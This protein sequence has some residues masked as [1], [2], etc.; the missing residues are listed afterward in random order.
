MCDC[1]NSKNEY[2][3]KLD[4]DLNHVEERNVGKVYL[5]E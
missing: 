2:N 4:S 5:E 3:R 1:S